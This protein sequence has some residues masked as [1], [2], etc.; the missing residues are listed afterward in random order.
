MATPDQPP[1]S[2][3]LPKYLQDPEM[4]QEC[5][6]LIPTLP[7]EQDLILGK[8]HQYQGFWFAT[9]IMQGVVASQKHFKAHHTDILIATI[10]KAG[11]TWL[12]AISFALLNRVRY[13][14]TE[15]HPLLTT[16]PHFLVPFLELDLYNKKEVPDLTSFTSPRLFSTHL[17]YSMLPIFAKNST[18]KI[19]YLCRNP[20]DTFVSFWHFSNK[21]IPTSIGT[22]SLEDSFDMFCRGVSSFGPYWDHVLGYWKESLEKPQK[23]LFLKYEEM[24]EQP[25]P[26]LR[27]LAEFLGCPF[28]PEEEAKGIVNDISRLCSFD[29]LSILE[30]N[31]TGKSLYGAENNVYFRRGEVGDWKNSLTAEMIEKLDCI[32]EEKF[33]GSGLRF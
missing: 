15:Q 19:V 11:T 21:L 25:I 4:T 32:T 13:A 24:K 8:L 30:V 9:W 20:K 29:N 14:D 1:P 2:S 33:H 23:V 7:T 18:C 31:K 17:P 5:K 12:K 28:S 22:H 10:P 27:R 16:N 3:S 6:D 26:N